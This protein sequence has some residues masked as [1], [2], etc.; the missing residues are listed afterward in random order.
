MQATSLNMFNGSSHIYNYDLQYVR[1]SHFHDHKT[2]NIGWHIRHRRQVTA[3][4]LWRWLATGSW[5]RSPEAPPKPG[6]M[7]RSSM[8]I[9]M[10]SIWF[11]VFFHGLY[12]RKKLIKLLDVDLSIQ[13][14]DLGWFQA[15]CWR[16][17]TLWAVEKVNQPLNGDTAVHLIHS[18]FMHK[19]MQYHA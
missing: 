4:W 6:R 1:D 14:M 13:G 17:W 7:G 11:H 10:G 9:P 19:H 12:I 16:I 3:T 15:C 5:W 8:E 18:T 2:S